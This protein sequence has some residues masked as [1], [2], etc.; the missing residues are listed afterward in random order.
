MDI[1]YSVLILKKSHKAPDEVTK[2]TK[3]AEKGHLKDVNLSVKVFILKYTILCSNVESDYKNVISFYCILSITV[4]QLFLLYM[5]RCW[6]SIPNNFVSLCNTT[7]DQSF[8]VDAAE[9]PK[10]RYYEFL[11]N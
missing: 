3:R 11:K 1:Y 10:R 8:W 4:I 6:I 5:N 2:I 9:I 7:S